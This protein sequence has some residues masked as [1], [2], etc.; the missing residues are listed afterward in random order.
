MNKCFVEISKSLQIVPLCLLQFT[1]D[2][3]PLLIVPP[4]PGSVVVIKSENPLEPLEVQ[5]VICVPPGKFD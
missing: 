4:Q 5:I 2:S 3:P 1:Y